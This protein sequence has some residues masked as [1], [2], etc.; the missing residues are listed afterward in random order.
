MGRKKDERTLR[1]FTFN[2]S[3]EN[4]NYLMELCKE[5]D[6]ANIKI[7]TL[8][9]NIIHKIR[10]SH[11]DIPVNVIKERNIKLL[12][13]SIQEKRL[14]IEEQTLLLEKLANTDI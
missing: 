6:F 9:D 1:R 14:L 8:L 2:I 3:E 7:G 5:D 10:T 4:Y 11:K 12:E 13:A